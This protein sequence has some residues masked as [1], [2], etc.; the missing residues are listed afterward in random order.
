MTIDPSALTH[1][2]PGPSD[3]LLVKVRRGCLYR[4]S[5]DGNLSWLARACRPLERRQGKKL[6]LRVMSSHQFGKEKG[7]VN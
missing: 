4:P 2:L 5:V 1:V 7:Y 3:D 6:R